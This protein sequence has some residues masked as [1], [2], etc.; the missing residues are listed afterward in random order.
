MAR[1]RRRQAVQAV[2]SLAVVG[3]VFVGVLPK[4][5]DLSE[6]RRHIGAMTAVEAASLVAVALWNL[7][8]YLFVWVASLPGLRYGQAAVV[9]QSTTAVAN[10][11]PAGSALAIGLT[12]S[13]F[14]SWGFRRSVITLAVL[15]SGIWN[16]FVKL[17]L[18][19]LALALLALQGEA[20]GARIVAGIVGIATLV[21]AV[22]L[23]VLSLRKEATAR[24]LGLFAQRMATPVAR[25]IR[26]GPPGGWDQA[27]ASFRSKTIRLLESRWHWLT[28]ATVVSHLSLYLVL[29][30][31]LRHVGVAQ[32]EISWVEV[33][34]AFAF[35]RL[36]SAVPITPGGLGVIELGLIAALVTAG[37]DRPQVVAA[38]LV[39]R[40]L[41]Y[42]LPIPVGVVTY[43]IW[44]R[45]TRWR[46]SPEPTE[47]VPA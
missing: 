10:T 26:R 34:A 21:A 27:L 16:N 43:L 19:V 41:T 7:A 23:F 37:G 3:A 12:Y 22:V 42:L 17:G 1:T 4:V 39:Y 15:V 33:L 28:G 32:D 36:L 20:S 30:V 6:V 9:T 45:N 14:S 18:P 25:L 24:R 35:V 8:T 29:L 40:A 5:A 44:R 2:V 38:V 13:M 47:A 11:V 46:R 31:A